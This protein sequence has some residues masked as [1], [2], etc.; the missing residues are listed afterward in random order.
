[1]MSRRTVEL[2]LIVAWVESVRHQATRA[3][4][5]GSVKPGDR[6]RFGGD[7]LSAEQS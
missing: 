6:I 2:T 4:V 3:L 5:T 1:M 7:V